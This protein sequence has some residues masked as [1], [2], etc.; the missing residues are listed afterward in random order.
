[1]AKERASRGRLSDI[2]LLPD[3]AQSVVEWAAQE[4]AKT[5][6]TQQDILEEFN[7]R[8]KIID[9]TL[10]PIS[11]SAFNRYSIRQSIMT[12]RQK[13]TREIAKAM[14][15]NLGTQSSDEVTILAA[16]AIK[17]L[18]FEILGDAGETGLAPVE[19]M[20]LATA[21]KQ[22]TAAQ[23]ISSDRRAKVER[24]FEEK[25][26]AAVDRVA[27]KKGI[28]KDAANTIKSA[29]LGVDMEGK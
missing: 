24:E 25:A 2:D 10:G 5:D 14:A 23:H 29:I 9:P 18:I 27:K 13:N 1:M 28:S 26:K 3:E 7:S 22:A 16:E 11:R 15:L 8:L 21:L 4:L 12:R 20:R 17:T 6:R 19:A